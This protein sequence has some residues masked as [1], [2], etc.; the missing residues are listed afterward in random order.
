MSIDQY[1][2]V[3]RPNL[4]RLLNRQKKWVEN[5]IINSEQICIIDW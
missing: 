4:N 2:T 5:A 3:I 1:L